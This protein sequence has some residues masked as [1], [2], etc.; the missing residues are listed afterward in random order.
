M[1][2]RETILSMI[3]DRYQDG[4]ITNKQNESSKEASVQ[5]STT[6]NAFNGFLLGVLPMP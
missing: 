6:T 4:A 5:Y 1:L 2:N 3:R